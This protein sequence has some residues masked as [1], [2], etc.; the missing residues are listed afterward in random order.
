VFRLFSKQPPFEDPLLGQFTRA[1]ST[2]FSRR[3]ATAAG[4]LGV[5]LAGDRTGP[6]AEG[7]EVAR[8]LL[9]DPTDYI[10]QALEFVRADTRAMEFAHGSGEL[11]VDGFS[12][13]PSGEWAVELSLSEWPDAMITVRF[14]EG[15]PCEVLLAD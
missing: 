13:G 2:W 8:A 4:T 10:R 12:V 7:L 14:E 9:R 15:K 5:T 6:S 1:G 3:I 11:E